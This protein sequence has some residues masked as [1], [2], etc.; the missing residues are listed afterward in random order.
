MTADAHSAW[1][2]ALRQAVESFLV[3]DVATLTT[4]GEPI[5][6]P[7]NPYLGPEGSTIEVS[8]GVTYPAKA[9]RARRRPK[10][11]ALFSD[12]FGSGVENAPVV[13]VQGLA[14][15]RDANLQ[16]NTDRY[17]RQSFA[18][19]PGAWRGQPKFLIQAQGWYWTRIY[20]E[21]TPL[22][23]KWWPAGVPFSEET[24]E[25]WQAPEGTIALRSD[26]A[27]PGPAPGAWQRQPQTW[28]ERAGF[29]LERLSPPVLTLVD[30]DGFPIM[31]RASASRLDRDGFVLEVP[32][33]PVDV[34]P[35][36]A[37]ATF[38]VVHGRDFRGQE[39]AVFV[40]EL[41][42]ESHFVVDRLLPDF[43]LPARGPARLRAFL[44]ARGRL[45]KRLVA[46]CERRGQ[47]VPAVN[48]PEGRP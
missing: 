18:K 22:V 27:P 26:P 3:C 25:T 31:T 33:W 1:P 9:E 5:T 45:H 13:F 6:W 30:D 39:N 43:S 44:G 47:L 7:L 38:S 11:G 34:V 48:L 10:V 41:R 2:A 46:E 19:L 42:D 20:L 4:R 16:A 28:R 23:V 12:P 35:G 24:V 29:A 32:G 15:V 37:C 14:A 8:T 17:V 36:R 40:G 21:I